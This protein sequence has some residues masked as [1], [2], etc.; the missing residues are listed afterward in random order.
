[1]LV[2]VA[3]A[4]AAAT[5]T[6]TSAARANKAGSTKSPAKFLANFRYDVTPDGNVRPPSPDSWSW[7]WNGVQTHGAAFPKCTAEM[8]DA[9]QSNSV[10][11]KG[12]LFASG[13]IQG[14]V[15]PDTDPTSNAECNGKKILLYN[16]GANEATFYVDGPPDGCLGLGY[17]APAKVALKTVKGTTTTTLTFPQN[18]THPLPGVSSGLSFFDVTFIPLKVKKGKKTTHFMTSSKCS[19]QRTFTYTVKDPEGTHVA[20]ADAGRCG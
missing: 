20:T 11:P 8:I 16:A 12:S 6:V 17:L 9:A 19:G 10:C 4:M 2:L 18:L 15:G 3:T 13:P 5:H 7:K 14:L 1:M